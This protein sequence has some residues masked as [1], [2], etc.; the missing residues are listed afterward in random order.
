MLHATDHERRVV[1]AHVRRTR[2]QD[3]LNL[4]TRGAEAVG[5]LLRS[6]GKV[7]EVAE[8]GKG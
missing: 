1:V 3:A 4:E 5:K 6:T 8:P 2:A 7:D